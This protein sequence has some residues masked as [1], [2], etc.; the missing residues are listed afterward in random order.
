[1]VMMIIHQ[2]FDHEAIAKQALT[3][4]TREEFSL[5]RRAMLVNTFTPFQPENSSYAGMII[6]PYLSSQIESKMCDERHVVFTNGIH[7][8]EVFK[9]NKT[10]MFTLESD[11]IDYWQLR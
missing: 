8:N 1:M 3:R 7:T 6:K 9:I 4:E 2:T 5:T 10:F 11:D